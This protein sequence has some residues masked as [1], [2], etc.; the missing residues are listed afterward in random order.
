[1]TSGSY[2]ALLY[3]RMSKYSSPP[4]RSTSVGHSP[5]SILDFFKKT[6]RVLGSSSGLLQLVHW[7]SDAPTTRLDLIRNQAIS[8]PPMRTFDFYRPC[9]DDKVSP[10]SSF[11]LLHQISFSIFSSFLML[12]LLSYIV[13]PLPRITNSLSS[14]HVSPFISFS[15]F[16]TA[17]YIC[18]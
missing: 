3:I 13:S 16:T 15:F 4:S 1:L 18:C 8:Y 6:E 12:S 11:P 7:Q 9:F 17:L 2:F 14:L 5:V 10:L